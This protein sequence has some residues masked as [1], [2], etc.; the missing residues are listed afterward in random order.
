MSNATKAIIGAVVAVAVLALGGTW[1]YINVIKDDAPE[2]LSLDD[3]SSG[4][5]ATTTTVDL[6]LP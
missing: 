2:K 4:S 1:L 3:T 6:T 5:D